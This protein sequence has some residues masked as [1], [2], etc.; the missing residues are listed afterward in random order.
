MN[1]R[2]DLNVRLTRDGLLSTLS[3]TWGPFDGTSSSLAI[4]EPIMVSHTTIGTITMIFYNEET[5]CVSSA[6]LTMVQLVHS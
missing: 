4:G 6:G 5:S 1:L 3:S 2:L